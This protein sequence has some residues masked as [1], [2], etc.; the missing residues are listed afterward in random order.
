MSRNYLLISF[1]G[2]ESLSFGKV[3]WFD[4][5]GRPLEDVTFDGVFEI[6]AR[7][8][9]K[10]DY[11]FVNSI[12]RFLLIHKGQEIRFV[13]EGV[14]EFLENTVGYI[15]DI[16]ADELSNLE[17]E[18][19][20]CNYFLVCEDMGVALPIGKINFEKENDNVEILG[21]AIE[22]FFI[23]YRN[24]K[25]RFVE[26]SDIKNQNFKELSFQSLIEAKVFPEVDWSKELKMWR[27]K[28]M[29]PGSE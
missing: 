16:E 7:K 24:K 15:D 25:L 23:V 19:G 21:N 26:E 13:P 14:D 8:W 6:N 3:Y 12:E 9:R 29:K 17:I 11:Y 20:K 28:L 10:S 27:K 1:D 2:K 4:E 5:Y 18:P 22:K